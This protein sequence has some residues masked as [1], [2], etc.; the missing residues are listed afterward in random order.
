MSNQEPQFPKPLRH[1]GKIVF[2]RSD[3]EKYKRELIAQATGGK[4]DAPRATDAETFV[5]AND[6]AHELGISRRTLGRIIQGFDD[7]ESVRDR[8]KSEAA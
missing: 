1:R 6:A 4:I 2:L 7:A 8:L 3:L 5:L